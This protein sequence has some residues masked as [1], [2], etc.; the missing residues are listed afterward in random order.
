MFVDDVLRSST[1]SPIYQGLALYRMF[2]E[3]VRVVL[4]TDDRDK[5]HRW[6]LEHRINTFDDLVDRNVPGVLDDPD[7][8]QVK[9]CRSQGKVELVVT[10]N[11]ELAKRL[12]EIGLDTLLFL[13][14][15]YLR[16]EFRPDGRQGVK[17][18][19]DIENEIDKQ[20]EMIKED[21]RV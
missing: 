15:T 16:P 18:W 21:P 11:V 12:L 7:L 19:A 2:N 20:I 1:G 10:G 6:L 14:P 4:L 3:D 5:T 17:A 8:E 9:Y 13:H